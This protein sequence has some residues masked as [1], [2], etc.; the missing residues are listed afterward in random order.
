ME[1]LKSLAPNIDFSSLKKIE[2]NILPVNIINN[3]NINSK[4][5]ENKSGDT[6]QSIKINLAQLTLQETEQLKPIIKDAYS[7][8]GCIFESE[9]ERTIKDFKEKANA[10]S[11]QEQL[12]YFEKII[13]AKD[14][15]LLKDCLYLKACHEAGNNIGSIK[16]QIWENHGSRG[17]NMSNLCSAGYFEA[18]LKPTYETLKNEESEEEAK[19]IFLIIYENLVSELPWTVFVSHLKS[20]K[21]VQNE[22]ETKIERNLKY[23]IRFLNIHGMGK[24][25]VEKILSVLEILAKNRNDI[26]KSKH[27]QE[28]HR[29]FVRLEIAPAE[30]PVLSV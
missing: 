25:N 4:V 10:P 12:K 27:E 16:Q 19:R 21:D 15:P 8:T 7:E 5:I 17:N 9:A 29:I 30:P 26:Q 20:D 23:G 22:V 6:L 13:P 11:F 24:S 1:F 3:G 2:I 18:W 28:K 14:I